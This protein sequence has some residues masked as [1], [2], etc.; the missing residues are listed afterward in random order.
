MYT[1]QGEVQ[2]ARETFGQVPGNSLNSGMVMYPGDYIMSSNGMYKLVYQM[3]GNLGIYDGAS[4]KW[5]SGTTLYVPGH[6]AMR[7]DGSFILSTST[8][9]KKAKK[10]NIYWKVKTTQPG[11]YRLVMQNDMNLA[12]YGRDNVLLW[13]SGTSIPGVQNCTSL[14]C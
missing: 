4:P 10:S 6:A 5:V 11:P 12:L 14:S 8:H 1:A 13:Q 9:P 7:N 3:N 2:C